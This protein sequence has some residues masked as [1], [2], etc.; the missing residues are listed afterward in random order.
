MSTQQ[1]SL[2]FDDDDSQRAHLSRV[3]SRIGAAILAF[4]RTR[5]ADGRAEFVMAEL[6]AYVR[7]IY[8]IAPASPDRILRALRGEG[9]CEYVVVNRRASQYRVISVRDEPVPEVA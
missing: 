7:S 4:L 6:H 2:P 8:G 3:K 1:P 9:R 5:L